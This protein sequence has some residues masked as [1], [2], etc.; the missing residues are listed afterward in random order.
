MGFNKRRT[1]SNYTDLHLSFYL[2][3]GR[4]ILA[5]LIHKFLMLSQFNTLQ[6]FAKTEYDN[7]KYKT[8]TM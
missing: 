4:K 5:S 2:V 1:L 6:T 3:S 7:T 8:Q